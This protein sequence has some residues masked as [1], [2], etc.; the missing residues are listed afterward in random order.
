MVPSR[1]IWLLCLVQLKD[2]IIVINLNNN[3]LLVATVLDSTSLELPL[4]IRIP[5]YPYS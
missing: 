1:H 3:M 2:L 4:S 5:V